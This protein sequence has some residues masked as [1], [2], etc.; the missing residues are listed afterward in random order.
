MKPAGFPS[1]PVLSCLIRLLFH[2]GVFFCLVVPLLAELL[3]ALYL[4]LSLCL[5]PL[6]S[7]Q[8]HSV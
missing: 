6:S 5:L 2:F 3:K 4:A 8:K 7:I 1:D